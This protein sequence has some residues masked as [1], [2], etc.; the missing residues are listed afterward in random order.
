MFDQ[1]YN[2]SFV[3]EENK[4]TVAVTGSN[5]TFTW[6]LSLTKQEKT[7]Q[8]KVQ[9]GPWDKELNAAKHYLIAFVHEPSGN[10]TVLREN[11]SITKRL[12]W[13]GDLA[14]D[15]SVAFKLFSAKPNDSGEYG[16]RV[17]VPGFPPGIIQSWFT[18]SV[19]VR[20]GLYKILVSN[21]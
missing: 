6:K 13:A 4:T 12:Y 8:L 2:L 20:N 7:K 18:L 9:F 16:V 19:Q 1:G 21:D 5:Q 10:Q 14:H 15:Y 11:N 3:T 17:R